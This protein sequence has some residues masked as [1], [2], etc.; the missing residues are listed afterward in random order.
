MIKKIFILIASSIL[1]VG[2]NAQNQP[3]YPQPEKG[4][5]RVDLRLPPVENE[6][7]CKVEVV[8]SFEDSLI[9]C[10][11]ASFGFNPDDLKKEY[12]IS[13]T[14]RFPY[15]ILKKNST[16]I[17]EGIGYDCESKKRIKRKIMSSNNIFIRYS[18]FSPYIFYI[19]ES[20]SLEYRVWKTS[21]NY[22]TVNK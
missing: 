9:E 7:E 13:G 16:D 15:Y 5:K 20:W 12:G 6:Q 8:F 4:F 19:P 10:S 1:I 3:S 2:L 18:S 11:K 17:V 21:E 14:T 22:I